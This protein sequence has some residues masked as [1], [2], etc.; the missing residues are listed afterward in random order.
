MFINSQ[1]NDDPQSVSAGDQTEG[2]FPI[3]KFPY[4]SLFK[5]DHPHDKRDRIQ[6]VL[7][8]VQYFIRRHIYHEDPYFNDSR[9]LFQFPI[10]EIFHYVHDAVDVDDLRS[11]LLENKDFVIENDCVMADPPP[12]SDS[13]SYTDDENYE[14]LEGEQLESTNANNE[15][16]EDW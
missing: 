5:F 3:E 10:E 11:I 14:Y 16:E 8:D 6:I 15:E 9:N 1:S 13:E 7:D 4:K 2:A 12:E